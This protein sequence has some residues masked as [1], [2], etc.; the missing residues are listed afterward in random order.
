MM[1]KSNKIK[2]LAVLLF[3]MIVFTLFIQVSF[4]S[5]LNKDETQEQPI[6]KAKEIKSSAVITEFLYINQEDYNNNWT[7][8]KDKYSFITGSGTLGDPYLISNTEFD[9]QN[10]HGAITINN[11]KNVNFKIK[12]CRFYN[13][14]SSDSPSAAIQIIDSR[15]GTI[16]GCDFS[17]S[18]DGNI[19]IKMFNGTWK[20]TIA[21]NNF[22]N[23]K[24]AIYAESSYQNIISGNN[25]DENNV[26]IYLKLWC[27]M[28]EIYNN[29]LSENSIAGIFLTD[30][31]WNNKISGNIINDNVVFGVLI[32]FSGNTKIYGNNSINNNGYGIYMT[33]SDWNNIENNTIISNNND[34]VYI[35]GS[36]WNNF[37]RNLIKDNVEVGVHIDESKGDSQNNYIY[38][39]DFINNG[40]HAIDYD[41]SNN[42]N[43]NNVG[44]KWDN[45]TQLTGGKDADDDGIGDAPYN[46]TGGRDYYPIYNDGLDAGPYPGVIW[47]DENSPQWNWTWAKDRYWFTGGDGGVLNPYT[48]SP[49][50]FWEGKI[51]G[52]GQYSCITL[53]NTH[54]PYF[55]L[56]DLTLYNSG[57]AGINITDSGV[58]KIINCNSSNNGDGIF[59]D[60]AQFIN[61]SQCILNDNSRAGIFVTNDSMNNLAWDNSLS[62]NDYGIYIEDDS[63]NNNFTSNII[64]NSDLYGAYVSGAKVDVNDTVFYENTFQ[65]KLTGDNAYDDGPD[66]IWY[67]NERGNSWDDY[68]D[69]PIYGKDA[70]DDGIGDKSYDKIYGSAN[71]IDKYPIYFDDLDEYALYIDDNATGPGAHNWTWAS[72][73]L[74]ITGNG[75]AIDPYLIKDVSFN[76]SKL[77]DNSWPKCGIT[78]KNSAEYNIYFKIEN[79]TIYDA[80]D[81][82]I[83]LNN[84]SRGTIINNSIDIS[85]NPNLK[86]GIHLTNSANLNNISY[87]TLNSFEK[88]LFMNYSCYSN[89]IK[90]N[91][92]EWNDWGIILERW[93]S[94]NVLINNTLSNNNFAGLFFNNSCYVNNVTQCTIS[95]NLDGIRFRKSCKSNEIFENDIK[96]NNQFDSKGVLILDNDSAYNIFY[97]N[98]FTGNTI[99]VL[100]D[101]TYNRWN[102]TVYGN[103]IGNI[104]GNYTE[105]PGHADD[106]DDGI[107]DV[108]YPIRNS[109]G[110]WINNDFCPIYDDG[111]NGDKVFIDGLGV[112]P[113]YMSWNTVEKKSW[114]SGSGSLS[115]PYI[116][117][118]LRIDAGGLNSCIILRDSSKN[119]MF[120]DC[121]GINAEDGG[122]KYFAGLRLINVSNVTITNCNFSLNGDF[123]IYITGFYWNPCEKIKIKENTLEDNGMS[124]I[125]G[126]D[127]IIESEIH[128]NNIT[129]NELHGI[130]LYKH[131]DNNSIKWN[132]INDHSNGAGIR[133]ENISENN[134]IYNN[135]LTLNKYG[136]NLDDVN[137]NDIIKNDIADSTTDGIYLEERSGNFFIEDNRIYSST[138]SGINFVTVSEFWYFRNNV[139]IIDNE[140]YDN[141]EYGIELR[142]AEFCFIINNTLRIN[143]RGI[144]VVK[145]CSQNKIIGNDIFDNFIVGLYFDIDCGGNYIYKNN[146][147]G[148]FE[149]ADDSALF[150]IENQW[151]FNLK[152]NYW[153]DYGDQGGKDSNDDGV[154][155]DG[156]P[157]NVPSL[158]NLKD[159][160]PIW[161]DAPNFTILKPQQ[162]AQL[163]AEQ[164]PEFVIKFDEG[165]SY[166]LWYEIVGVGTSPIT[167]K[168]TPPKIEG[169]DDY[170]EKIDNNLWKN[171]PQGQRT[172]R[173]YTNDSRGYVRYNDVLITKLNATIK[174][175]PPPTAVDDDDDDG[176]GKDEEEEGLPWWLQAIFTGIISATAGLVIK[177]SYSAHKRKKEL[178]RKVS[179]S[180][181]RIDNLEIFLQD[182]LGTEE[183]AKLKG[184]IQQYQNHEISSKK[185]IK[186][187]K[188]SVG[189]R[190]IELFIR[191]KPKKRM[192]S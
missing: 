132:T 158:M 92:M 48:I 93:C 79:C 84:A 90:G 120:Y 57:S 63:D 104:W 144:G 133:I 101:G 173:F 192:K 96:R 148:N 166:H 119:V 111:H 130:H 69:A 91:F 7:V 59:L 135:W 116:I 16:T 110:A 55:I 140:I 141:H 145:R 71:S 4:L 139:T 68:P 44:N 164:N 46:F 89:Y 143:D 102:T 75:S 24:Y 107:G 127:S 73:R 34:G 171:T 118:G 47:I 83:Y 26:G 106:D 61:I 134:L 95:N 124:G 77:W 25:I 28:N 29:Y 147:T 105:I 178:Y 52:L 41:Y 97:E 179:D 159:L 128:K 136:I 157:Y 98:N 169:E 76:G 15:N 167:V 22:T 100:D 32:A 17:S 70:D 8:V 36:W 65:N 45:Y 180:F 38:E 190:F 54:G 151:Y 40:E 10:I 153:D 62:N 74:F 19:G 23:F 82:G 81:A 86:I 94:S 186:E 177:M 33:G 109:T 162:N 150:P 146:F 191:P 14:G 1:K 49:N 172:I 160:Y 126:F 117:S 112:S 138:E 182:K 66:T 184:P 103:Q 185:L 175:A 115:D 12:N 188:K 183:W 20:M 53:V 121:K 155:D 174:E 13:I 80:I 149:H 18:D 27:N 181:D 5:L 154:G 87:N 6:Q 30:S 21:N 72:K 43:K 189:K 123:G 131:C 163:S 122:G 142:D 129:D 108:P 60:E 35:S 137:Y 161:W 31:C 85:N 50:I 113:G 3:S 168:F 165:E 9:G 64:L 125:Y 187:S 37:T 176:A 114:C 88:G 67:L 56:E 99:H 42:W 11:S 78:I 156:I 2:I 58:G 51:D 152:G 39:N 170:I